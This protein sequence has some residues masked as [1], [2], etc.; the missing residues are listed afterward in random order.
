MNVVSLSWSHRHSRDDEKCVMVKNRA[1]RNSPLKREGKTPIPIFL[2]AITKKGAKFLKKGKIS[3]RIETLLS[4]DTLQESA[5]IY[6][7]FWLNQTIRLVYI[8]LTVI[9]QSET[10]HQSK[11]R[12]KWI[13]FCN[14]YWFP[15]NRSSLASETIVNDLMIVSARSREQ[16]FSL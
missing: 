4:I 16:S 13:Q 10:L 5:S 9:E 15:N 12:W 11:S 6:I 7:N 1:K 14:F 2:L 3:H 8:Y